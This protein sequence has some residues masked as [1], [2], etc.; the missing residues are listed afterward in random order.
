M[1][2]KAE[3]IEKAIVRLEILDKHLKAEINDGR[4][5]L[6]PL[7]WFSKLESAPKE[8]LENFQLSPS[9]YGIHWPDLDEDISIKAFLS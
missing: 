9:G 8:Q 1:S 2:Q 3:K 5:V 7:S 6:V 4:I